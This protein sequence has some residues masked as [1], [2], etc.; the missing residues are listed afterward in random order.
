LINIVWHTVVLILF[1]MSA[2]CTLTKI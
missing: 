2:N 1:D